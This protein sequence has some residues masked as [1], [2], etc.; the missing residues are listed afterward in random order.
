MRGSLLD[1]R[2]DRSALV[3]SL[4]GTPMAPYSSMTWLCRQ[5]N[6][7]AF[8]AFKNLMMGV[9]AGEYKGDN[10]A[11][12]CYSES[13]PESSSSSAAGFVARREFAVFLGTGSQGA[14]RVRVLLTI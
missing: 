11:N 3:A 1:E 13:E 10:V 14:A 8:A 12:V 9:N 6:L 5:C 7:K 4:I 2:P